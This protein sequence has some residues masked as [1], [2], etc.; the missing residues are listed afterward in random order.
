MK[1]T[2]LSLLILAAP[3][4][5]ADQLQVVVSVTCSPQVVIVQMARA[6]NEAGEA[7]TARLKTNAW[8]TESLR[9][10]TTTDDINYVTTPTPKTVDCHLRGAKVNI[11]IRPSFAPGWHPTGFCAA[12]TG[13]LIEIHRN[14]K[15]VFEDGH[16]AC[17]EEGSVPVR[18]VL[19]ARGKPAAER[20]TA[21]EFIWGQ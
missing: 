16:D 19:R 20:L 2:A 12:R 9:T 13:A 6:W 21:S 15:R 3:P 18:V 4:V 8:P 10:V 5:L 17:S 1:R 14:G 11:V 7:L